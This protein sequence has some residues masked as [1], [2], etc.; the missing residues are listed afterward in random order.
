M[1]AEETQIL[2]ERNLGNVKPKNIIFYADNIAAI[3]TITSGMA[4]KAQEQS[5]AFR[6]TIG[7]ILDEHNDIKTA[8]SWCPSHMG[9]P[10][11]KRAD[12][13]A[14][15]RAKRCPITPLPKMI[16]HIARQHRTKPRESWTFRWMN[17]L[18]NP[19]SRF[20]PM[21]K[22]PP[23]TT[24]TNSFSSRPDMHTWANTTKDSYPQKN[25]AANVGHNSALE[26]T[27]YLTANYM[28]DINTY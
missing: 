15:N 10:G 28:P 6:K 2:V 11:N 21:N 16:T 25:K 18:S 27:F 12:Y 13:L 8:I 3:N 1:A 17:T 23:L 26:N 4:H 19:N 5:L 22:K 24:P 9:I 7:Q 14:K 20:H